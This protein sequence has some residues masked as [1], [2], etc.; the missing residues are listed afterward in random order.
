MVRFDLSKY[1]VPEILMISRID[2]VAL[3]RGWQKFFDYLLEMDVLDAPSWKRLI[4]GTQLAKA[5]GVRPGKW[6]AT[7]LDVC[8][9]WQFRNPEATDYAGAVEEVRSRAEE[10]GIPL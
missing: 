4:D 8:M 6:M 2:Y 10:L 3:L 1:V 9:A 7:A 5:L